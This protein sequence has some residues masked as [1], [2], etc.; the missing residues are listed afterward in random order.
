MADETITPLAPQVG[1]S[2]LDLAKRQAAAA[3]KLGGEKL[4]S[5]VHGS[6]QTSASGA[7]Y[8][9]LASAVC[10][11]VTILNNSGADV[12]VRRDGAGVAIPVFDSNGFPFPAI[13]N[14]NALSLRRVDQSNT[15]VTVHY[16]IETF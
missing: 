8:V 2:S 9:T 10:D 13:A 4:A 3:A 5:V 14:A 7:T 15:Q 11:R 1:D 16:T 6:A 12:E